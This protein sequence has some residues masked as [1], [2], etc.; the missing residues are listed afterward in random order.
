MTD[1]RSDVDMTPSVGVVTGAGR[2]MGRACL[3]HVATLCDVVIAV[4]RDASTLE[5]A[6]ADPAIRSAQVVGQVADI[7][8]ARSV[9]ALAETVGRHGRFRALAHAAGIS[10][11]MSDARTIFAVDLVGSAL[12]L[13]ALSALVVPGSA[14]VCF[15]SMASHILVPHG[16]ETADGILAQPLAADLFDR[17]RVTVGETLDDPGFAYAWAKRGVQLLARRTAVSWGPAGGR[18][19]SVS[20]GMVDTPQG[21]Q[22]AEHQPAMALLEEMTPLQR[23]A[24]A[25]ELAAVVAFMLSDEAS[26]LTG[27]D[28]LV[29][30][31]VVAALAQSAGSATD[32]ARADP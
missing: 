5:E 19:C 4:D 1:E 13:E 21:R 20:P 8:D 32:M 6:T 30:G 9:A 24:R 14:A 15:S 27:V 10:P 25:E 28:I 16:E 7:S 12:M 3:P 2:G 29:D 17:M 31:G 22:E 26:F 23:Y 18:V 11:T